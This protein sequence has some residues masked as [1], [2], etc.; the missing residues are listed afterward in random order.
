[1]FGFS[2]HY[3]FSVT[4]I[5]TELPPVLPIITDSKPS[6]LWVVCSV[7]PN[8]RDMRMISLCEDGVSVGVEQGATA[9]GSEGWVVVGVRMVNDLLIKTANVSWMSNLG[10]LG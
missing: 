5:F 4:K 2:A 1:M 7:S 8:S 10:C 6:S 9:P 3:L